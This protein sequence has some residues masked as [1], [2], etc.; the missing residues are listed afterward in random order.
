[1][2]KKVVEMGKGK[3]SKMQNIDIELSGFPVSIGGMK[4]LFQTSETHIDE[5]LK[6]SEDPDAYAAKIIAISERHG[7]VLDKEELPTQEEFAESVADQKEALTVI[8]DLIL[9][10]GSF[11]RL[12][13]QYPD[14][15][16]LSKI[17]NTVIETVSIGLDEWAAKQKKENDAAAAQALI[18]KRKNRGE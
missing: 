14:V 15:V 12:Y 1:M 7:D 3:A 5:F 10:K 4:F 6:L 13:E 9:G 2:S 11:D 18:D 17:M 8:Y 16:A